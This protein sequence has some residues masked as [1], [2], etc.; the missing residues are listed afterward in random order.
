MN[1]LIYIGK[2]TSTHGIKGELKIKSDFEYKD[3][4]FQKNFTIYIK[5]EPHIITSYRQ[6]KQ[7]DM[8]TI[9]KI[10]D[11]NEIYKY[12]KEDVY[13]K[14]EDLKL[15]KLEYLYQDLI[16][17]EIIEENTLY[18]KVKDIRKNP[19]PLLEVVGKNKFFIPLVDEYIEKI[20][21][22][23]GYIIVKGAQNLIL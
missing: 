13:I 9:D 18:G 2:I 16:G 4:V 15:N 23:K 20:D 3:R 17:L 11:I 5:E 1:D 8:I 22:E 7:Y 14:K 12:V 21:I 19:I 10:Y 6:H